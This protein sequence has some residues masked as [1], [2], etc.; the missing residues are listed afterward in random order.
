LL[1]WT[2]AGSL[3]F[4]VIAFLL[5]KRYESAVTLMPPDPQSLSG[6]AML[7]AMTG[8]PIPAAASGLSSLLGAKSTGAT[9]IGILQSRT[10]KDDLVNRFDLRG[11][12]KIKSSVDARG[13]LADNT[14]IREDLKTGIITLTVTDRDPRRARDLAAGYVDELNLLVNQ[15]S[16]SSAR[17]ERI[18]L[19]ERLKVVK[20][21]LDSAARDLSQFSSRNGTL[22]MQSQGQAMVGAFAKLQGELIATESELRGLESIYAADN[23]RVR[24]A[25]ARVNELRGQLQKMGGVGEDANSTNPK[26]GQLY[27]SLRKLPLLGVT[28]YDLYRRMKIQESV[29]E[30]LTRQNELAKVQEAK[31]IPSVKVLDQPIVPERKSFPPRLLILAGG[32][33]LAFAFSVF[34]VYAEV[35]WQNVDVN[36]PGIIGTIKARAVWKWG[37]AS[38]ATGN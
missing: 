33:L 13:K 34:I 20:E 4:T 27:P 12:Y 32:T 30:I 9:F 10:A 35:Y 14:G 3:V 31:E 38:H 8:A 11:V 21:D 24:A 26:T 2:L 17:R 5:P 37:Q 25:Q 18:F 15:L 36:D 6:G 19:E 29:Y 7:A 28:Y 23:V 1:R 22:D 16:I